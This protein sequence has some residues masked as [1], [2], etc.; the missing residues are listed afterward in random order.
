M[1][2]GRT[3]VPGG[4]LVS[5]S[6]SRSTRPRRWAAALR[7]VSASRFQMRRPLDRSMQKSAIMRFDLTAPSASSV[8]HMPV[9]PR[10]MPPSDEKARPACDAMR[11]R[12]ENEMRCDG[13][14]A[15]GSVCS[16]SSCAAAADDAPCELGAGA[17]P[18]VK[19]SLSEKSTL[20]HGSVLTRGTDGAETVRG[21]V[22]GAARGAL[23][24]GRGGRIDE[25]AGA[26]VEWV[27]VEPDEANEGR[28][29][30]GAWSRCAG[31]G[32]QNDPA[33][34]DGVM[35]HDV[36][37]LKGELGSE[38]NG[39]PDPHDDEGDRGHSARSSRSAQGTAV[40]GRAMAAAAMSAMLNGLVVPNAAGAGAVKGAS[41]KAAVSR[42]VEAIMVL[43]LLLAV[44]REGCSGAGRWMGRG[45]ERV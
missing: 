33:D 22:V 12:G 21:R 25:R 27:R 26:D 4:S 24:G 34:D 8:S 41:S 37:S 15:G 39:E 36:A 35:A 23:G 6:S 13:K 18:D 45:S 32:R 44:G 7:A 19:R 9:T 42:E 10:C 16:G 43:L 11:S 2:S 1:L 31:G 17:L 20:F 14:K 40:R 28:G 5:P 30:R 29:G 3:Y 38:G